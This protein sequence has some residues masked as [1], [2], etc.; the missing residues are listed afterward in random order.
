MSALSPLHIG[1]ILGL[2]AMV[3]GIIWLLGEMRRQEV[4]RARFELVLEGHRVAHAPRD[5]LPAGY[6]H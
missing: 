2:L 5:G 1:L 3:G 4:L 6:R